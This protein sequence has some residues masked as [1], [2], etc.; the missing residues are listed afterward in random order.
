MER[1]NC[2]VSTQIPAGFANKYSRE[3]RSVIKY[4]G[5]AESTKSNTTDDFVRGGRYAG[6]KFQTKANN[7][8]IGGEEERDSVPFPR[9]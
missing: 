3:N 5:E 8:N 9:R 2:R 6:G 4:G 1:E 7:H